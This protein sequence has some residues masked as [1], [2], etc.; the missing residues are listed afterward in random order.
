MDAETI[1]SIPLCTR[2]MDD[3]WAWRYEKMTFLLPLSPNKKKRRKDWL[4]GQ[5][6]GS[7]TSVESKT[8]QR[9]RKVQ[10]S[11]KVRVFLWRMVHLS[12]PNGDVCFHRK[13]VSTCSDCGE[14]D[15]WRHRLIN[16]LDRKVCM[17]EDPSVKQMIFAM[18]E[19]LSC[20]DFARVVVTL[21]AI[22]YAR[23]NIIR[24]EEY[25]TPMSSTRHLLNL[26]VE[27]PPWKHINWHVPLYQTVLNVGFGSSSP[28]WSL[29]V[30]QKIRAIKCQVSWKKKDKCSHRGILG[31]KKHLVW[32]FLMMESL[33]R[34]TILQ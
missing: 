28:W 32:I 34:E 23:S 1:R 16:L 31:K 17:N 11:Y 7:N 33:S 19:T 10:V 14:V 2:W 22:C 20:D 5:Y 15:S 12:L 30:W 9:L 21:W 24:D 25:Q 8:W 26:K 4:K 3:C 27:L 18:M 13:M 6:V 29:Y